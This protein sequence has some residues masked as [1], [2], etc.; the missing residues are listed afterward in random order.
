MAARLQKTTLLICFCFTLFFPK[1]TGAQTLSLWGGSSFPLGLFAGKDFPFF[2]NGFATNGRSFGVEYEFKSKNNWF[3]YSIGYRNFNYDVDENAFE[4]LLLSVP[5]NKVY[6]SI[7]KVQNWSANGLFFSSRFSY[8][9]PDYELF[10]KPA[11]GMLWSSSPSYYLVSDSFA[12][13]WQS[14]NTTSLFLQMGVGSFIHINK[15]ISI[16][17]SSDLVFS[18][19][20]YG[21]IQLTAQGSPIQRTDDKLQVPFLALGINLGLRFNLIHPEIRANQKKSR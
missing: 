1:L 18:K 4:K 5:S 11:V 10:V 3:N 14:S 2:E 13:K 8:K 15:T 21:T 20:D 16:L 9:Q 19:P 17:V 6:N 12:V 7:F